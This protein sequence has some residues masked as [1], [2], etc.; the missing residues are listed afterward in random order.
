MTEGILAA[1]EAVKKTGKIV[2]GTNEV[3]KAL[4]KG[5]AKLVVVAKD[6]NPKE[7]VM[8]LPILAKEKGAKY[9][10]V[11]TKDELGVSAGLT[12]GTAAIA[13]VDA[14]DAEALIKNLE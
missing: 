4:E 12:R 7:I 14:G 2:K 5:E 6:V 8:H 3:T 1:I 10:E 11:E 13:V 9:A